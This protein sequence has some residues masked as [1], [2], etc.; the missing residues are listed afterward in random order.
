MTYDLHVG[1]ALQTLK[2][3]PTASAQTCVT[4]P[5]YFGLRDYGVVGQIGLEETPSEYVDALVEVFR[6]VR[7]ALKSDGTLWLNLGDSF[8]N[9]Q[10]LGIPWRVA[11]AL[12]EDGWWL[13]RDVIWHKPNAMPESVTDRPVSAHE[14][15]FLLS[16]SATYYYD[17]ASVRT[18]RARYDPRGPGL[19]NAYHPPGQEAHGG[20][21]R[22]TPK[23]RVNDKQ[24]G[25]GRRNAGFNDRWDAMTREEQMSLGSQLRSVWVVATNPYPGA[26]FAT[27]PRQLIEPC[28]LAG[29]RPGDVVLDPFN[30][31]GTTGEVALTLRRRYVGIELNPEYAKLTRRRL[32]PIA[33]QEHLFELEVAS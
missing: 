5:P 13:R 17:H 7:R 32:D 16:K 21:S 25:H 24:R 20:S 31:S 10:L 29:S 11:F 22:S 6:E 2:T 12:Q 8:A 3:L 9:K 15:V 18:P 14:Y 19:N 26:H 4:S 23:H 33:A 30:G 1:D 27:Y 28:V